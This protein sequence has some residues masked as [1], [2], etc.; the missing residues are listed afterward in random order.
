[1]LLTWQRLDLG[2]RTGCSLLSV[3]VPPGA[4]GRL[5]TK[6]LSFCSHQVCVLY[7]VWGRLPWLPL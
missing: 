1:M 5:G 6:G 3:K 2:D 4:S 7:A